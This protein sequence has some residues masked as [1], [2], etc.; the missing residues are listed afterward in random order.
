[1]KVIDYNYIITGCEAQLNNLTQL[2]NVYETEI[3]TLVN[4]LKSNIVSIENTGEN[5]I[6][7]E[8][9]Y[10]ELIAMR[11]NLVADI[12]V[13]DKVLKEYKDRK[14]NWDNHINIAFKEAVNGG[15]KDLIKYSKTIRNPDG[16]LIQAISDFKA[17]EHNKTIKKEDKA[18]SFLAFKSL[19]EQHKKGQ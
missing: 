1:M 3:K 5:K 17:L 6:K 12:S 9:E 14:T 18:M 2:A 8:R 10:C 4:K 13:R 19:L 15:I 16:K 7:I 11:N